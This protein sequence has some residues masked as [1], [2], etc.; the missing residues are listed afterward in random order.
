M[1]RYLIFNKEAKIVITKRKNDY[2][3]D[4]KI[5]TFEIFSKDGLRS[6]KP[7]LLN[8]TKKSTTYL[9]SDTPKQV[10]EDFKS[11]FRFQKTAGGIVKNKVGSILFIFND[12][13]WDLPKGKAYDGEKLEACALRE[14]T[15][16]CNV[17]ELNII[18]KTGFTYHLASAQKTLKKTHWY[19]MDCADERNIYPQFEEGITD[20]KWFNRNWICDNLSSI[21]PHI[22]EIILI[23]L[24][25]KK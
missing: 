19:E 21:K 9:F 7:E 24:N 23:Y 5:N 8:K 25:L 16:E 18:K 12:N 4:E 13:K 10:Y 11:L 22:R 6:I 3:Y 17:R 14:I 15:E 1:Q 2:F 20:V